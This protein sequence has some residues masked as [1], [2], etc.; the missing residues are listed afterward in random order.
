MRTGRAIRVNVACLAAC[1]LLLAG[2]WPARA[3]EDGQPAGPAA[4]LKVGD[5]APP[6][7]VEK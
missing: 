5:K 2:S 7:K 1:G 6:L 3:Q 4:T